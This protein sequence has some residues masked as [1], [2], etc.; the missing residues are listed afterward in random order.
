MAYDLQ[1]VAVRLC[2]A[3][4]AQRCVYLLLPSPCQ[5]ILEPSYCLHAILSVGLQMQVLRSRRLE[6]S[7]MLS[8]TQNHWFSHTWS[9]LL[10][11]ARKN[12]IIRWSLARAFSDSESAT[13]TAT[14]ASSV[15]PSE[16]FLDRTLL[17][18][19]LCRCEG[20]REEKLDLA[21]WYAGCSV[22]SVD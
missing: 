2:T 10:S 3:G 18:D 12:W 5:S 7:C 6:S 1:V 14:E 17:F 16:N 13:R 11:V 8:S 22:D 9:G 4:S 21:E 15:P 20:W 19:L